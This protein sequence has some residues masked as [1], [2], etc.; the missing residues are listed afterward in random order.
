MRSP[1]PSRPSGRARLFLDRDAFDFWAARYAGALRETGVPD[2]ERRTALR[3]V[4]PKYILRNHLAELAI[5]RAAD[6]RDYSEV[7]RLHALLTR[8]YDE[9]PEFEAY[10]AEPPDWARKIEVSCS[11]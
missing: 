10:A 5:R 11:S 6:Q 3:A 1:F 8:P 4:N 2:A 9:Q 7:A